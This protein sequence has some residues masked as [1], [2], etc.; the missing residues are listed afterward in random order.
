[1]FK[2][3]ESICE[4][5]GMEENGWEWI[6]MH[7]DL[8]TLMR[9]HPHLIRASR[10]QGKNDFSHYQSRFPLLKLERKLTETGSRRRQDEAQEHVEQIHTERSVGMRH[11]D[12]PGSQPFY[13]YVR[14]VSKIFVLATQLRPSHTYND[15]VLS[16]PESTY[17]SNSSVVYAA[18]DPPV[19]SVTEREVWVLV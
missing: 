4:W 1:M 8:R 15:C 12:S 19:R 17:E 2:V 11:K 9:S 3:D 7:G 5:T 13:F 6:R 10:S 14:K 18:P 16:C